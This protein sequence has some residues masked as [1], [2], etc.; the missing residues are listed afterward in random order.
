MRTKGSA[1]A[2]RS[3]ERNEPPSFR[4]P[5]TRRRSLSWPAVADDDYTCCTYRVF[6]DGAQVP[7]GNLHWTG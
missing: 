7:T 5:C 1:R 3:E 2:S 4:P 6:A